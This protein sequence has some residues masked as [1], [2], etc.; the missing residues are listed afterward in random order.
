V[1]RASVKVTTALAAQWKSLDAASRQKYIDLNEAEKAKL[2]AERGDDDE[3]ASSSTKKKKRSS[4]NAGPKKPPTPVALFIEANKPELKKAE[5]SLSGGE[6]RSKLME[7]WKNMN[8]SGEHT[9]HAHI[10]G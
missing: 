7:Q 8:V 5:P 4:K 10:I 3:A 9:M 6:L 2:A 1:F